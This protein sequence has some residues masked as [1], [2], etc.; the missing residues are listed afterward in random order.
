VCLCLLAAVPAAA[1]SSN[2]SYSRKIVAKSGD[3]I[4]GKSLIGVGQPTLNTRGHVAF[5][6]Y[7]ADLVGVFT[8]ERLVAKTGDQIAGATVTAIAGPPAI[9]D[10]ER[11]L[12]NAATSRGS[13]VYSP[14]DAVAETGDR[15]DGK[16]LTNV[17][18]VQ[19]TETGDFVFYS[20]FNGGHGLFNKNNL[21]AQGGA[22][23]DG[24][25]LTD[26]GYAP[27]IN[28]F[29]VVAAVGTYTGGAGIFVR[30]S[31]FLAKTGDTIDGKT[32]TNVTLGSI[33]NAGS[34][35]FIGYFNGGSGVF[36]R[37]A[38]VAQNGSF[39]GKHVGGFDNV[40]RND[41]G[42]V[43]FTSTADFSFADCR[44][45]NGVFTQNGVVAYSGDVIDGKTIMFIAHD[46]A[47]N[48]VGQIVF[49]ASF[50]DGTTGVVL[51]TPGP[52][53]R[54]LSLFWP[55]LEPATHE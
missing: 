50:T 14:S 44:L 42:L 18:P 34:L 2:L 49:S 36:T 3:T 55:S 21:L 33:D 11:I 12:F 45:C 39:A 4:S 25:T 26:V 9:N 7:T 41:S 40:K 51:A 13:G 27:S 10:K 32:L 48:D 23:V 31:G 46:I 54:L 52:A 17:G 19:M 35:A 8:P 6:A 20:E 15:I 22:V 28:D 47:V 43:A 29:G 53:L 1:Q 38:L 16:V 5:I 30:R 24:K 37:N